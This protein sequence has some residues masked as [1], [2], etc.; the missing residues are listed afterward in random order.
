LAFACQNRTPDI[1]APVGAIPRFIP[2]KGYNSGL[3]IYLPA[4]MDSSNTWGADCCTGGSPT[5]GFWDRGYQII[6]A[7]HGLCFPTFIPDSIRQVTISYND[8]QRR[9]SLIV[10]DSFLNAQIHNIEDKEYQWR[11]YSDTFPL[12]FKGIDLINKVP[13]VYFAFSGYTWFTPTQENGLPHETLT[14]ICQ[15]EKAP[16]Y[17]CFECVGTGCTGFAKK[18]LPYAR[19]RL[20]EGNPAQ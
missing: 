12:M 13:M 2:L 5:I 20:L 8:S 10:S 11:K 9:D 15:V 14:I 7:K 19:S 6:Q 4:E 17:I 18:M 3:I 1:L 16:V